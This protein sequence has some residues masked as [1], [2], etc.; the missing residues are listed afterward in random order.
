MR[1]HGRKKKSFGINARYITFVILVFAAFSY[2]IFGAYRLQIQGGE[3]Y[4]EEAG[5]SGVKTIAVKGMRGMITDVNSVILAKSETVYNVT[6]QRTGTENSTTD[7]FDF[8]QSILQTL[9]I[10]DKYGVELCVDTP[11]LFNEETGQWEMNFGSGVSEETLAKREKT[12]RSNNYVTNLK[13]YPDAESIYLRFCERYRLVDYPDKEGKILPAARANIDLETSLKVIAVYNEM[14]DNLFNSLPIVIAKDVPFSAVS[15]IEGR[16]MSLRGMGIAVGEKRVYPHGSLAANIIGYTSAIQD[17]D[18]YQEMLKPQGY[19]LNDH[20]GQS[21]VEDSME[22]WLTA[23]ITERQGSRVVEKDSAG[24]IT[25]ELSYTQPTDGNTV[26]LTIDVNYQEAAEQAIANNVDAIRDEQETKMQNGNWLETNR[27]KLDTRDWTKYPIKL[28]ETGVLLVMDVN[29]GN[30]LASAQYPTYDLNAM[31]AGGKAA[32]EINTDSRMPTSNL[33]IQTRYEP[34]SIFKMVTGLAALTNSDITGFTVNTKISDGGKFMEYTSN[35]DEAPTCWTNYPQNH[36]D[37]TI[38]EGLSNSCN[39][40]FYTLGSLLYG[41]SGSELSQQQLLYKYAAKMGLT[42]KTGIQL[43]GEVRSIVGN[44]QNMYD[45]SVSLNEQATNVADLTAGSIKKL[46]REF[47]AGY[48]IEYD[49]ARLDKTVKLLMDM[50]INTNSDDWVVNARPIL[51]S[52]LNMTR[53]MV[54]KAALMSNLW[55]YLNDIKWGGSQEIQMGIGQSITTLTP[56]SVVRY[57]GALAE[58]NVWNVNVVDSILSPDG[59]LL[60]QYQP[61]LF[62]QLDDAG[63]YLPYIQLGMKGVV[64]ESGTATK[65]F[66]DW[67]YDADEWIMGKTG[68]SQ[69]TRGNVKIDL[70]NNA[71]FVCLAPQDDPQIAVVSCVPSGYAGAQATRAVRDFVGWY[72]DQLTKVEEDIALP[73]GNQL[74]P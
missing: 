35:E 23:C 22:S 55:V 34:G 58:G 41:D 3:A 47:G 1:R 5:M 66:R 53:D 62:N 44:Q 9:D 29:N 24:K 15:E 43:P 72:L 20:I 56:M 52:E 6:F 61:S 37:Q 14:Q 57:V 54:L 18:Y 40:F 30:L 69:V 38:I 19:A 65:Y 4:A 60:S 68:T 25:R 39:Y 64:D 31:V 33:A 13:S 11:L 21:G 27:E 36:Q 26:K 8:T 59:E 63:E 32:A 46:I 48:G 74:T 16:S 2:M 71:W 67:K 50:A 73:G 70:E 12:F 45:T 42:S 17:F 7:Y 10:L 51:M 49:T 28:A